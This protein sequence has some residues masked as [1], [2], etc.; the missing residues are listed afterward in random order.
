MHKKNPTLSAAICGILAALA[1]AAC[2]QP[3]A[4]APASP[5]APTSPTSPASD[6]N[7]RAITFNS[8]NGKQETASQ[9]IEIGK[10]A[11]LRKNG[12]TNTGYVFLGW[13]ES[14]TG[15]MKYGDEADYTMGTED[16]SLYA[17][18]SATVSFF[19]NGGS[20]TMDPLVPT[21]D[22]ET[23]GYV[24]LPFNA[25]T[26]AAGMSLAGWMDS[27]TS[28]AE[29]Y[30]D[31]GTISPV[32]SQPLGLYAIWMPETVFFMW[33]QDANYKDI[34]SV[35]GC[36]ADSISGSLELPLGVSTIKAGVFGSCGKL[37]KVTIPETVTT[38]GAHAFDGCSSLASVTVKATTPPALEI[39]SG[40]QTPDTFIN[41]AAN[42]QIKVPNA[43][44][45]AYKAAD[46]WKD[47]SASIVGY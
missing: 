10:T 4:P 46:G 36:N 44:L 43:S 12:F 25:F 2:S 24:R 38:I 37:S 26:S 6:P 19:A 45:A 14:K 47:Y 23:N 17:C 34:L 7:S 32:P 28:P 8:R 30:K 1:L 22:D 31:G 3:T 40:E 42:L 39:A 35:T 18:W 29:Y 33:D 20:G 5:E 41:V 21:S 13:A 11:K 27:A 15:A 16:V 9:V